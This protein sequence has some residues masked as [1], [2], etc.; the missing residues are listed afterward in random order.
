MSLGNDVVR[1]MSRTEPNEPPS[2]L[3]QCLD[4]GRAFAREHTVCPACSGGVDL[5]ARDDLDASKFF[6]R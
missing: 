2:R 3:Y 6:I 4:C 1:A 5:V